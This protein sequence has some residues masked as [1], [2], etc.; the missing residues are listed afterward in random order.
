MTKQLIDISFTNYATAF[1]SAE[2]PVLAALNRETHLKTEQPVMLSGHLQGNLLQMLSHM[3][4]PRR[5]LELGTF[6]G[7]S[8][9]CLAQGLCAGGHLHTIELNEELEDTCRRYFKEAGVDDRI[10]MHIGKGTDIIPTLK[11]KWDI[12]FLDADKTN[13]AAYFDMLFDDIPVGG[14]IIADNVLFE[15]KVMLPEKEQGKNAAAMHQFNLKIRQD[16]R[17]EH[18]LLPVRDGISLIRK[19]A[20]N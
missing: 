12:V 14:Y 9:I 6:T 20:D 7:Y 8:A 17:V 1:S 18:I 10:T 11:E 15:G 19:I 2:L 3:I 13:Y 4:R 16:K 5:I